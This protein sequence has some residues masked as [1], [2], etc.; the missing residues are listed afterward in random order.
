MITFLQS[1]KKGF[2]NSLRAVT[3]LFSMCGLKFSD[4]ICVVLQFNNKMQHV[5]QFNFASNQQKKSKPHTTLISTLFSKFL[6][7]SS[8]ANPALR[9][10]I[11]TSTPSTTLAQSNSHKYL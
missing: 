5:C 10:P 1:L 9:H 6:K 2:L 3:L 8:P 11:P 7:T 4:K